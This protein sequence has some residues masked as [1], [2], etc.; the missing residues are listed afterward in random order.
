MIRIYH[1]SDLH[2]RRHVVA[3]L[4]KLRARAPG[5]LVDCG[6]SLR[7]SQTMYYRNEPV[8]DELDAA[9]YDVTAMGNREFHY[10][11]G[12]R[13][14]RGCARCG[15][16]SCAR[17]SPTCAAARCRSCPMRSSMPATASACVSSACWCR[18]IRPVRRGSACSA[19]ASTIRTRSRRRSSRTTPPGV[20]LVALS[21]LGLRADRVLAQRVPQIDVILG[22]H[23]H[24]TLPEPEVVNGVPIVHAGPYGAFASRTELVR[25]GGARAHR[26][27][28]AGAA[29]VSAPAA[30]LFVTNGHGEAAIAARI[31]RDVRAL[32]PLRDRSSRA[33]RRALRRRA[34]SRRR[35]AAR[36]AERRARRDGQRARVR[37]RSRRGL[38][39]FVRRATAVLERLAHALR[40]GRR[41]RRCVCG[42]A[43]QPQRP[44]DDLR[45]HR[46]ERLRRAVRC[47]RAAHH[48]R[49]RAHLR[50]RCRDGRGVTPRAACAP[51]RR[52]TS[53]SICSRAANAMR[54]PRRC[55][56]ALLPGSRERAYDDAERLATIAERVAAQM[57]DVAAVMSVAPSLDAARFA[58]LFARHPSIA[59][60]TGEIGG[61]LAGCDDRAR[62]SR[63]RERSG[64]GERRAGRRARTRRRS[65]QRLVSHASRKTAR[66]RDGDRAR[67]ARRAAA[68]IVGA[69]ARCAHAASAWAPRAA[70]GWAASGG[71]AAIAAAIAELVAARG[72]VA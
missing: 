49:R 26:R 5:L 71:A 2:D 47:G 40:G 27:L 1:T 22:G 44:A 55:G 14:A 46:E 6:D 68:A 59:A 19:G 62:S 3:P 60:W 16:P 56:I 23:S 36:D 58:P 20:T 50:A 61:I 15:T 31:A 10:L 67:R 52:A 54:G 43:R 12:A 11:F 53:S 4:K 18:S 21:H 48:R 64:R 72:A 13:A 57:P 41:G 29:H 45:R 38:D 69:A 34:V 37:A 8:I 17:I 32:A 28:R 66:R 39:R 65:A 24:D 70:N 9:G 7:G 30:V 25:G 42:G 51:R 63:Y 33:R 35:A